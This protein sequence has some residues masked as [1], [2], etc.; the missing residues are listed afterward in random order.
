MFIFFEIECRLILAYPRLFRSGLSALG[1]GRILRQTILIFIMRCT[2]YNLR[3]T[4][5]TNGRSVGFYLCLRFRTNSIMR[6]MGMH[7]CAVATNNRKVIP[8]NSWATS[9]NLAGMGMCCG[10]AC[11]QVLQVLHREARDVVPNAPPTR[12]A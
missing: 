10:Q 2:R 6:M 1:I 5:R 3:I 8:S 4:R 11:I 7:I 9:C 12:P